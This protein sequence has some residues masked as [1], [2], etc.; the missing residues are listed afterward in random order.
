[1]RKS[2]AWLIQSQTALPSRCWHPILIP[3]PVFV[4]GIHGDDKS[5]KGN[6]SSEQT[7]SYCYG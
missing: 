7:S 1:M 3:Q 5:Q 4:H 6:A 2:E